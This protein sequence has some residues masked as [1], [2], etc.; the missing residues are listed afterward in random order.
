MCM[1]NYVANP[2]YDSVFK[3]L[4]EDERVAKTLLSALLKKE[5]VSVEVRPNEYSNTD[6]KR[7]SI[8][9]IDF[10]AKVREKDGTEHLILIELQKTWRV[11]EMARFRQ[12]LGVQY[13]N[14][15]NAT[16]DGIPLPIV[17][18]YLLGHKVGDIKEPVIY[19]SR[20]YLDYNSEEITQGVPDPFVESLTHDSIIVQI[21]YLKGA[22]RNQLEH[23]L[24]MFDQSYILDDPHFVS[25]SGRN[26]PEEDQ[27]LQRIVN[28]LAKA[29][30]DPEIRHVMN[31]E[32]E[33]FSELENLDT[34]V[35]V[36]KKK[37]VEQGEQIAQQEE[38]LAQQGE[39]LAQQGEQLAQ[40]GEQIAAAIRF[41]NSQGT[42]VSDIA[43][44]LG[45][46]EDVVKN[47]LSLKA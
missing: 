28:R 18:I 30:A 16:E 29:A 9:R 45:T 25:I 13:E 22:A 41:L 6:E 35:L 42:S 44:I 38:Q 1:G 33:I 26:I 3:F 15:R 36:Q 2:I 47:V 8:F 12:Y 40:Q 27:D 19:V 20:K 11:T 14:K 10:G 32:D 31:I 46:S 34:T 5:V 23:T 37:I 7:I 39:Q 17:S 21:P 4:L 24:C 43:M